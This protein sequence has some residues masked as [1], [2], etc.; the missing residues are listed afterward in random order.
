[1]PDCAG[2]QQRPVPQQPRHPRAEQ[3]HDRRS[4]QADE[5]DGH[6]GRRQQHR[7]QHHH[8]PD[9]PR[10][11]PEHRGGVVTEAVDV[12]PAGQGDQSPGGQQHERPIHVSVEAVLRE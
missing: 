3:P 1:M 10:V 7:E 6:R 12:Q 5:P 9:L 8:Q 2:I 4:G 11:H